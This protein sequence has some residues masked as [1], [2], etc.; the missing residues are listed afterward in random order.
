MPA[1]WAMARVVAVWPWARKRSRATWRTSSSE[2]V[3]CRPM[4][5]S[6]AA[7]AAACQ[8]RVLSPL[9]WTAFAPRNHADHSVQLLRH[10]L[11]QP[12]GMLPSGDERD[13]CDHNS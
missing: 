13:V 1:A 3:L 8:G 2:I 9:N 11:A 12:L 5:G 4:R 6:V 10:L 7:C